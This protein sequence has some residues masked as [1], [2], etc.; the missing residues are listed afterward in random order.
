MT[1]NTIVLPDTTRPC[2]ACTGT[3]PSAYRLSQVVQAPGRFMAHAGTAFLRNRGRSSQTNL[4]PLNFERRDGAKQSWFTG[5]ANNV[6]KDCRGSR[7]P[8]PW[9]PQFTPCNP[10]HSP[11][12]RPRHRVPVIEFIPYHPLDLRSPKPPANTRS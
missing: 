3:D 10:R 6:I 2:P 7:G 4:P 5:T 11:R 1:T 8:S 12:I 9:T